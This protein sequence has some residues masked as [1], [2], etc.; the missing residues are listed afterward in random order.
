VG[1]RRRIKVRM[2]RK[3]FSKFPFKNWST[4]VTRT[5]QRRINKW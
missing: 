1:S 2:Q 5:K 3:T 4:M